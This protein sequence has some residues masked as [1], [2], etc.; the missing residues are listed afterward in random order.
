MIEAALGLLTRDMLLSEGCGAV[1]YQRHGDTR[2]A[3]GAG[4]LQFRCHLVSSCCLQIFFAGA[5]RASRM[6]LTQ[7]GPR[8]ARRGPGGWRNVSG[9]F[10]IIDRAMWYYG[11][12]RDFWLYPLACV[13]V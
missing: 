13:R 4:G 3:E 9:P 1:A 5:H 7:G 12:V 8:R 11:A 2:C 6:L 10:L